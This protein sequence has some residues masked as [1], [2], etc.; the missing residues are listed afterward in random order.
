MHEYRTH[1][2]NELNLE[3][4]GKKVKLSGF[5]KTIRDLGGVIFVDLRDH[6]G[7]TQLLV[8]TQ[9]MIEKM[10]KITIE[11]T[12]CVE[13]EVLKKYD[14]KISELEKQKQEI[15]NIC[16]DEMIKLAVDFVKRYKSN[17]SLVLA[18]K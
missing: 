2:C 9:D 8:N 7:V 3:D 6:Y 16:Y 1:K 13:G 15:Q 12:I 18:K 11:S 5:V 14:K 17:K 4:V 10:S